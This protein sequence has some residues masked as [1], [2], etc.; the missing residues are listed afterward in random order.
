MID[1]LGWLLFGGFLAGMVRGFSGFGTAMV[2]LPIAAQFLG[3]FEAISAMMVM[4]VLGALPNAWRSLPDADR[5]DVLR[6][7]LGMAVAMPF[8]L[9][10]LLI[11]SPGTFRYGVS[12]VALVLLGLLIAGFR[13]RGHLSRAATYAVGLLGG[14]MGGAVGLPGPP[15][16]FLYMSSARPART[17]RANNMIY[18]VL[19]DTA[20][21]VFMWVMGQLV[22]EMIGLGLALAVCYMGGIAAGGAIFRP[23]AER[24]YRW[25]AY[26]IIAVSALRGLPILD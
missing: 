22:P 5:A 21:L 1:G 24:V 7:G 4:A 23:G 17:I 13:Y 20:L 12:V 18:L 10:L 16:I 8:G 14:L 15:V 26:A 2:F 3:R 25:A 11:V 19:A 9:W 6:L